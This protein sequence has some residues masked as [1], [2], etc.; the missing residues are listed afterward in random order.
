MS[1]FIRLPNG[2]PDSTLVAIIKNLTRVMDIFDDNN[3][4]SV[5]EVL[6]PRSGLSAPAARKT[7]STPLD[8]VGTSSANYDT[9]VVVPETGTLSSI[10]LVS[11]SALSASDTNYITF[12]V[13]NLGTNGAGSTVML[14][15]TDVNTTKATGGS[16]ISAGAPRSLTLTSTTANLAVTK[17][18]VL[19][20]R[21]AVTGTLAGA[22][23]LPVFFADFSGTT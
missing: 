20:I 13:T 18:Q 11:R 21:A 9:F 6:T 10:N 15:A 1:I 14:A 8:Q 19:R 2:E 3:D 7:V 4:G 12:T 23:E 5:P 16:A 17:G 22:V